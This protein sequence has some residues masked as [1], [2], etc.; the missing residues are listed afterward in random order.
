MYLTHSETGPKEANFPKGI[1]ADHDGDLTSGC[2]A[3][4][5]GDVLLPI[6]RYRIKGRRPGVSRSRVHYAMTSNFSGGASHLFVDNRGQLSFHKGS[7]T[8]SGV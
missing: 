7:Y 1:S 4:F 3:D 6:R 5:D 2:M 8:P